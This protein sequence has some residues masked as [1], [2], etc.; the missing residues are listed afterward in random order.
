MQTL[1]YYCYITLVSTLTL[2]N[3]FDTLKTLIGCFILENEFMVWGI[4]NVPHAK[5]NHSRKIWIKVK[6]FS[7][8]RHILNANT[9]LPKMFFSKLERELVETV[10]I[11]KNS[12]WEYK[13]EWRRAIR[14]KG[15]W[16]RGEI[17]I[18]DLTNKESSIQ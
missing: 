4:K 1:L 8:A 9:V 17:Q 15:N 12:S 13:C 6:R 3:L 11:L 14:P 16:P 2:K 10:V 5:K 18:F 7:C